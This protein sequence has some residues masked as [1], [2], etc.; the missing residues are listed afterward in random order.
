MKNFVT[1]SAAAFALLAM[2]LSITS[3]VT[4]QS[5]YRTNLGIV[6]VAPLTAAETQTLQF[7][8]EEEK[9]AR[10]VYQQLYQKWNLTVFQNISA[11]E[12]THFDAIGVLLTRYGVADPAQANAAGVY[13]DVNLIALYNEVLAKG[14]KSAQDALEAGALIEKKDIADLEAAIPATSKLD[15]KRVYTNLLNGSF[16]HLEAFESMC[17]V[18]TAGVPAL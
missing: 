18:V 1:R 8:R 16:N 9:L 14:M 4:A 11:A 13:T 12:Q 6:A 15:V 3:P 5:G 17:E 2:L 7:M 10:D